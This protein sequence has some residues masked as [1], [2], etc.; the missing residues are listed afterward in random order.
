MQIAN[1]SGQARTPRIDLE[2]VLG[3][4]KRPQRNHEIGRNAMGHAASA[5]AH[6]LTKQQ[7]SRWKMT[8]GQTG[9]NASASIQAPIRLSDGIHILCVDRSSQLLCLKTRTL[10][11]FYFVPPN[12][13]SRTQVYDQSPERKWGRRAPIPNAFAVA[14]HISATVRVAA[15]YADIVVL[16][17]VPGDAFRASPS[18]TS[19]KEHNEDWIDWWPDVSRF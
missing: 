13:L 19:R 4:I 7:A 1:S 6:E 17:S 15:A 14:S 12:S 10:S 5:K 16:Y 8:P 2:F 11:L 18:S 3:S 9:V